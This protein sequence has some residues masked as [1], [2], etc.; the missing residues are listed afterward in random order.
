MM[1]VAIS[2][3]NV[4]VSHDHTGRSLLHSS[5]SQR[6]THCVPKRLR[7]SEHKRLQANSV[8]FTD[9]A[10][11]HRVE[12]AVGVSETHTQGESVG[13]GVVEGLAEGHQVKLDQH[14][15]QGESLVRQPAD[16][17][18]K[19]DDGDGARHF[20]AAALAPPL[21]FGTVSG[22]GRVANNASAQ[23]EPQQEEVAHRNDDEWN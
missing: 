17:K 5:P 13:L 10:V 3:I 20:G 16:E 18:R 23:D 6:Q 9:Q 12:T 14:P 22:T 1:A 15:P 7:N 8:L 2:H 11:E 21:V 19:H 4:F